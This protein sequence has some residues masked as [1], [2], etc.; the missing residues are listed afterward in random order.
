MSITNEFLQRSGAINDRTESAFP[1]YWPLI[2]N[3]QFI[4]DTA[5]A[6]LNSKTAE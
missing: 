5:N 1:G 2:A 3:K 4:G 6:S